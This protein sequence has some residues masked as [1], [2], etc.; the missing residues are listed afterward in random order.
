MA[1]HEISMP[2]VCA[3]CIRLAQIGKFRKTP[4]QAINCPEIGQ[5]PEDKLGSLPCSGFRNPGDAYQFNSTVYAYNCRR[6]ESPD[7]HLPK[8]T[9]VGER[10]IDEFY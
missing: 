9:Y 4:Q 8:A 10:P 1:N 3:K 7:G 5:V 6:E 2:D